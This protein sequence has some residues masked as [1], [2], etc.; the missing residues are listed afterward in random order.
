MRKTLYESL[1]IAFPE[2][3]DTAIPEEQDEFEHFVR[4]LNSYYSNI[5]K[6]ELDDFRQNGIDECHR[7]QQL[8]IDLDELK[9]QINDDMA[10]F[11]KCMTVR[12]KKPQTCMVMILNLVLML[13]LITLK[14]L[15]SLM[16][17]VYWLSSGRTPIG[18]WY[19]I[20]MS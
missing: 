17:S 2:L 9:N 11:I 5:Q 6:I 4:W 18:C 15:L 1:R 10:S 14:F 3:N 20:M 13:F 19:R 7:L 8:G 16:N 12:K